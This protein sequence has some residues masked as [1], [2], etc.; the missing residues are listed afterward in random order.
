MNSNSLQ[1]EQA[2]IPVERRAFPRT[3]VF[4]RSSV[5]LDEGPNQGFVGTLF[6]LSRGGFATRLA[7]AASAGLEAGTVLYCVLLVRGATLDCL[8][9]VRSCVRLDSGGTQLGFSIETLSVENAR[10]LAGVLA[11]LGTYP[12]AKP[13]L[14]LIRGGDCVSPHARRADVAGACSAEE[15]TP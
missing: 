8:A 10:L 1:L 15:T 2:C 11:Y 14:R 5:W 4:T 9:T 12:G 3:P 7:G 13:D 6:D